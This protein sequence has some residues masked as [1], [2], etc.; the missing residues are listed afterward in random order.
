[1]AVYW[2]IRG[3][4]PSR[5]SRRRLPLPHQLLEPPRVWQMRLNLG[6]IVQLSGHHETVPS[7]NEL[8]KE[9]RLIGHAPIPHEARRVFK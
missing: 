6:P 1:M 3:G 2:V 4:A 9:N 5:L 8:R 7:G